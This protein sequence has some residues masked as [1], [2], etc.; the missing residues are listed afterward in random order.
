MTASTPQRPRTRRSLAQQL[1]RWVVG[2]I[3]ASFG[4]AALG[5]VVVLLS[6]A[7]TD[8][9]AKVLGTTAFTGLFSV[10]VLCGIALVGRRVQWF[11]WVTVG[12]SAFTLVRILWLIWADPIWSD[13][14]WRLTFTASILTA[15]CAVSS[16]LLLLSAH[17]RPAV[18]LL[19]SVTLGFIGLGVLLSLLAV[20][21]LIPGGD[22]V[23]WRGTGVVW[24]LAA[25][26]VVVLPVMSLLMRDPRPTPVE[27]Q[28]DPAAA[29]MDLGHAAPLSPASVARIA[30]AARVAGVS[31]DELVDRLLSP[32]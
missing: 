19:L 6:G 1:R 22:E 27:V 26:G 30:E 29:P 16:L 13:Y 17:D 15:A 21:E 11:G 3:I 32:R 31:P 10:A 25:L 14:S 20:W 5:G 2:V 8:T 23:F 4:V 24:I 7:W 9:V 18:R 12:V 28:A